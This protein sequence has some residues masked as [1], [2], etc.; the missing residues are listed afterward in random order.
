M[1][2]AP[3]AKLGAYEVIAKVG[4]GGMGEVYRARDTRLDRT[5]AIKV[6]PQQIAGG[7]EFRERFERE[8]RAISQLNH[9]HIC[10][11]YDIGRE[12]ANHFLVLEYL[13]GETLADR[14][15][16]GPLNVDQAITY[17]IQIA[18]ALDAAHRRGILHRDLKP[19][20]V[21]VTAA[22][23]KLLDF[24]LAKATAATTGGGSA[25]GTSLSVPLT[26]TTPLTSQG[27]ILGTFQYM[28]PEVIDGEAA[29]ARAD[30]WAFGC[31]LYEMLTGTRPFA[32]KT[33]ASL[34]GAILKDDARPVSA[35]QPL[36]PPAL[37][38]IVR[39]CLAKDPVQ[40]V[41]SAH[42]LLLNLQWIGE[43]GSAAGVPAP[44]LARRRSRERS[45][46]IAAAVAAALLGTLAGWLAKPASTRTNPI[47]RFVHTLPT[48]QQLTRMGRHAVA[49]AP[50][51]SFF[52]Y[53]ANQQL[54]LR[55]MNQL[56]AQP[57]KG[58]QEDPVEPVISPDGQWVA[59]CVPP[60]QAGALSA[61]GQPGATLK[62][63]PVTGGAPIVL[64]T[65]GFPFGASWH[66]DTI[67]IG[68]GQSGI[69]TVPHGGGTPTD[70]VKLEGAE[71]L[72]SMPLLVDEGRTAVFTLAS[73]TLATWN[74]ADIVAQSLQTGKRT[75]IVTGG[76]DARVVPGGLLTYMRDGTLFAGRFDPARPARVTDVA[77][78]VTGV[79]AAANVG[80]AGPGQYAVSMDGH[81]TYVMNPAQAEGPK[82]SLV[83]VDRGGREEP[84]AAERRSYVAAR[85][86]PDGARIALDEGQGVSRNIWIWDV[87]HDILQRLTSELDQAEKRAPVWLPT[88]RSVIYSATANGRSAVIRIA[89]DGTG[90][91][92]QLI[93]EKQALLIPKSMSP[94]G[95]QLLYVRWM[96]T[97]NA[98]I[99]ALSITGER[100]AR[101]LIATPKIE[102]NPTIS[103]NGR[104][105][106]YES[107]ESGRR[108]IYVR[109]FPNVDG[110]RW[111]I[112]ANGGSHAVWSRNG[113]DL[114]FETPEQRLAAI[115]VDPGETTFH[116][117]KPTPL[118]DLKPYFVSFPTTP[119]DVAPDG[120]FVFIKDAPIVAA[121]QT[122]V[123]VEHW[124][125][126]VRARLEKK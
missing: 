69:V 18:A 2:L 72:A 22:G 70:V 54:Y 7:A 78:L 107:E 104:W 16:K 79:T 95:K 116:Y 68:Q 33:Q 98:D 14:L 48:D 97:T 55:R 62:K 34:L 124:L 111:Q 59:Y 110:G 27:T 88:S 51:G 35:A 87:Q 113:R 125:D 90:A 28:A 31:V 5:V 56:E 114:F 52:I 53:V 109:A 119:Y 71:Q 41:Q 77:P 65:V 73:R 76:H 46:W 20:N 96:T 75:V 29:D 8:A 103:P 26:V 21:M 44:I 23:A 122:I 120:R 57:I 24:G 82:R 64:A 118:F 105:L 4:E 74:D 37:E 89:A 19:G 123:V 121:P 40:R 85:V 38:R 83:W 101:T 12:G 25:H 11:L 42:D 67:V 126:E 81:L 106:S 49:I 66:G 99:A 117:G 60:A 80:S 47:R 100:T 36:V 94:D 43:G 50:D 86:A 58:T 61:T 30:I 1:S 9:P 39:T 84:I 6:L 108:E 112:S 91:P 15:R 92:E 115:S 10:T 32:G 102:D 3:G 17:A 63:I 93:D 45:I 13:E